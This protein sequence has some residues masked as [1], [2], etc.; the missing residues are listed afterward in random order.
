LSPND[1]IFARSDRNR[2]TEAEATFAASTTTSIETRSSAAAT[3]AG[4]TV[5][6]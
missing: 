6:P 3:I 1:E 5:R 2:R 4:A